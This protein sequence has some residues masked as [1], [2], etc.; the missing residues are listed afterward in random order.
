MLVKL[1]HT[2]M[3]YRV[4]VANSVPRD[5]YF[6]CFTLDGLILIYRHLFDVYTVY[7]HTC[8]SCIF[9]TF[10][11]CK[12]MPQFCLSIYI[13]IYIHL[14]YSHRPTSPTNVS[15]SRYVVSGKGHHLE[16]CIVSFGDRPLGVSFHWCVWGP[17]CGCG[18]REDTPPTWSMVHVEGGGLLLKSFWSRW[19]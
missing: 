1:T 5:I 8:S 7:L 2:I 18:Y 19:K 4:I 13:Y 12:D 11:L 6:P 15:T 16:F 9:C 14:V 3:W 10:P 17:S